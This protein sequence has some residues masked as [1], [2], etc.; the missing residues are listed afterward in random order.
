MNSK[1]QVVIPA[2]MRKKIQEG[3]KLVL[4]Q[5]QESIIMKKVKDF[6]K[7]VKEDIEDAKRTIAEILKYKNHQKDY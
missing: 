4:I 5:T 7:N 6:R 1:G 2:S 3:E